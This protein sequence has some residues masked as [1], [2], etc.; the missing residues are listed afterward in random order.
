MLLEI[1]AIIGIC[2]VGYYGYYFF[3]SVIFYSIVG[4]AEVVLFLKVINFR[5]SR[6][7]YGI[8]VYYYLFRDILHNFKKGFLR[9]LDMGE[10]VSSKRGNWQYKPLW[11]FEY[12]GDD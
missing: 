7:Y 10:F 8:K 9:I 3:R 6:Q 12:L 2:V 4:F 11:K 5:K 1:F